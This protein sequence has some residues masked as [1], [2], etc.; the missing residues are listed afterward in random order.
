MNGAQVNGTVSRRCSAQDLQDTLRVENVCACS[1]CGPGNQNVKTPCQSGYFWKSFIFHH[2]YLSIP[3]E[4]LQLGRRFIFPGSSFILPRWRTMLYEE[5]QP[6]AKCLATQIP[7]L[8]ARDLIYRVLSV[9]M[10]DLH[11]F[12]CEAATIRVKCSRFCVGKEK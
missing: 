6:G 7:S 1:W 8:S 12:W 9:S 11:S 10:F 4:R 5:P 2:Q 3:G